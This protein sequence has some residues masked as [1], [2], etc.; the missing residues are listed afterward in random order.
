MGVVL[1]RNNKFRLIQNLRPVRIV[2]DRCC[3]VT[4]QC[5]DIK[6]VAQLIEPK[7]DLVIVDIKNGFHHSKIFYCPQ[8]PLITLITKAIDTTSIS[9]QPLRLCCRR[10]DISIFFCLQKTVTLLV[11]IL[12]NV[13]G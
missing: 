12:C 8:E 13:M 6:T 9:Y 3:K 5:Q 4:F 10:G 1:K 7:D 2:N 11:F